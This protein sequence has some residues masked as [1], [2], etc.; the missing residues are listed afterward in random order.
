MVSQKI[1]E[2]VSLLFLIK[3]FLCLIWSLAFILFKKGKHKIS[4]WLPYKPLTHW[5]K[6]PAVL[7]FMWKSTLNMD[8]WSNDQFTVDF[9][10]CLMVYDKTIPQVELKTSGGF[11]VLQRNHRGILCIF[12]PKKMLLVQFWTISHIWVG[13]LLHFQ[14]DVWM[15]LFLF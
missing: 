11:C 10:G 6:N 2:R 5:G 8:V 3:K 9:H 1:E 15:F 4:L 14:L 12:P 13:L 7:F